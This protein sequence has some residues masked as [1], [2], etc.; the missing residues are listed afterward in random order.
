MLARFLALF[1]AVVF[2]L[3]AAAVP[4]GS[5]PPFSQASRLRPA[6]NQICVIGHSM[7]QQIITNGSSGATRNV[8]LQ[9]VSALGVVAMISRGHY[10][11]SE[12]NTFA[13]AGT[14]IKDLYA[15][16]LPSGLTQ[17]QSALA[18]P[19]GTVFLWNG[20]HNDMAAGNSAALA[21]FGTGDDGKGLKY[22]LDTLTGAGKPVVVMTDPPSGNASNTGYR[23]NTATNKQFSQIRNWI[24]KAPSLYPGQVYA[25]DTFP[26]LQDRSGGA[27]AGDNLNALVQD[28]VHPNTL[29]AIRIAGPLKATL[30]ALGLPWTPPY[31]AGSGDIF[32]AAANTTGNL[33]SNGAVYGATTTAPAAQGGVTFAGNFP[34][35]L[36]GV[37]WTTN[38]AAQAGTL[39][40]TGSMVTTASGQ[41]FQ[42]TVTGTTGATVSP[43]IIFSEAASPTLSNGDVL[44]CRGDWEIDPSSVGLASFGT[45]LSV[46][47]PS[48]TWTSEAAQEGYTAEQTAGAPDAATWGLL[49]SPVSGMW[50]GPITVTA[51]GTETSVGCNVQIILKS[52]AS[53]NFTVR[54]RDLSLR[55]DQ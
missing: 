17:L 14:K 2:T 6:N 4:G 12:A 54:W 32:D 35:N 9:P 39:T 18:A 30:D 43:S 42:L 52:S 50:T 37:S 13:V 24:L 15:T 8:S 27:T 29:A 31:V 25:V 34:A 40:A 36:G 51:T 19:C 49:G 21:L 22:A 11:I 45:R 33:I 1:V 20:G 47:R 38:S 23:F 16:A 53:P 7:A 10:A 28:G 46:T 3:P 48:G 55:K 26:L 44:R 41:W 5:S